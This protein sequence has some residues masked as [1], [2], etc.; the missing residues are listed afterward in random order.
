MFGWVRDNYYFC[1]RFKNNYKIEGKK[2]FFNH[3]IIDYL[4]TSAREIL[5]PFYDVK[6]SCGVP[7]EQGDIP[8]EMIRVPGGDF[9]GLNTYTISVK[10]DSMVGVGIYDGD[11][12]LVEKT[13]QIH[14]KD[15]IY[16]SV[17]GEWVVKNYYMDDQGRHWLVPSNP[18]YSPKQL[19][20]DMDIYI[21]GRVKNNLTLHYDSRE[22]LV[23]SISNYLKQEAEPKPEPPLKPTQQEVEAAL[24]HAGESINGIRCW[25]GACSVLMDCGFIKEGDYATFCDLERYVLPNHKRLPK[26]YEVGRMAVECFSKPFDTWTDA[27]APVHGEAYLKYYRAGEAMLEMLPKPLLKVPQKSQIQLPNPLKLKNSH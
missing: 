10:G 22:N 9:D 16:I 17:D 15:I 1:I 4:N 19:T 7:T 20:E 14:N 26:K 12:L 25:L 23:N 5:V 27:T 11:V 24:I 8:P 21:G 3:H 13:L 2:M 18:K 6:A